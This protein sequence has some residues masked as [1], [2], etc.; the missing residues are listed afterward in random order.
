MQCAV[1]W[2]ETLHELTELKGRR[3]PVKMIAIHVSF[4]P[5]RVFHW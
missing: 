1:P 2:G 3:I 5:L 4:S